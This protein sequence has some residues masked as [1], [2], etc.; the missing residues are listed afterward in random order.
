MYRY[1]FCTKVDSL[2]ILYCLYLL[3][4]IVQ[5]PEQKTQSVGNFDAVVTYVDEEIIGNGAIVSMKNLHEIYDLYPGDSRC[6]HK[7]K[8]RLQDKYGEEITFFQTNRQ[9][10]EAVLRTNNLAEVLNAMTDT[11]R[12]LKNVARRLRSNLLTYCEKIGE[13]NWPPTI[14]SVAEEYGKPPASVELFLSCVL[15]D[16][17]VS[18]RQK[19][20]T[21]NLSRLIDSFTADLVNAASKGKVIT[22]KHYLVGLGIHNMTGQKTPVQIMNKLGHSIGYN[23][24]CE[25]ETSLAELAIHKSEEFNVLPLLPSGEEEIVPTFYW[26]DNFD[27][28]VEKQIGRSGSVNTTHLMAFQ[29]VPNAAEANITI[30][31]AKD[32]I[33]LDK[34]RSRRLSKKPQVKTEP[35]HKV[36]PN[37]EPPKFN[38]DTSFGTH[39]NEPIDETFLL[40]VIFLNRNAKDQMVPNFSGWLLKQRE[41]NIPTSSLRQTLETYLPPIVSKVSEFKT[42]E[43]YHF[44][45]NATC[46]KLILH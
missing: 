45:S 7:L 10:V 42:I 15:K 44:Q 12:C 4:I 19:G 5:E 9:C 25:I 41:N 24:V 40:W 35:T 36:N 28:K 17:E 14:E 16:N 33:S 8:L 22:P 34:S 32:R 18:K 6:R 2:E 1:L 21:E 26:V 38:K 23:K 46:R 37:E 31:E 43:S 3:Y 13:N 11:D 30:Q 27:V 20:N 39:F 29:E